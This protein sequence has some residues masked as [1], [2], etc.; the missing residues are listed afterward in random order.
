MLET[1]ATAPGGSPAA[2]EPRPQFYRFCLVLFLLFSTFF[3]FKLQQDTITH[4]QHRRRRKVFGCLLSYCLLS[5]CCLSPFF[6]LSVSCLAAVCLLSC[7]CLSPFLLQSVFCLVLLLST[8]LVSPCCCLS[9]FLLLSVSLL[10]AV[11]SAVR[12][13]A[14]PPP[15]FTVSFI[16]SPFNCLLLNVSL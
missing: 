14:S 4:E 16:L 3:L 13:S 12:P 15:P 2:Q 9:P 1:S 7:C 6:L 5:S 10:F 8:Q 11:S